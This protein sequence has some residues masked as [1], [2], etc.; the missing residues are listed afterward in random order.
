MLHK[1]RSGAKHEW[2]NFTCGARPGAIDVG[3]KQWS[4]VDC[5]KCLTHP[6]KKLADKQRERLNGRKA[7]KDKNQNP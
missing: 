6:L 3:V 5:P 2:S 1:Q 4:R 7:P